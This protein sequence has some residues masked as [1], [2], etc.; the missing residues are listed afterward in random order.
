MHAHITDFL[1]KD[2]GR[3]HRGLADKE[4]Y[5]HASNELAPSPAS[6]NTRPLH[7]QGNA[8]AT[9]RGVFQVGREWGPRKLRRE[10]KSGRASRSIPGSGPVLLAEELDANKMQLRREK[11]R[12]GPDHFT[13]SMDLNH[14][15][16][17]GVI[18]KER[19]IDQH[20]VGHQEQ[21]PTLANISSI[22]FPVIASPLCLSAASRRV[23]T[24][25]DTGRT[26]GTRSVR[27]C[28][29]CGS[30]IED[31]RGRLEHHRVAVRQGQYSRRAVRHPKELL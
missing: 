1:E 12:T 7:F 16:E 4:E 14:I 9:R 26:T 29:T 5:D 19:Y 27:G 13:E 17:G 8:Q 20:A 6:A 24:S 23:K 28:W 18:H 3:C 31:S 30:S 21:H 22:A 15:V 2:A 10:P 11:K 25:Y